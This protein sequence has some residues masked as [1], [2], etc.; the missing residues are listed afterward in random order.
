MKNRML[1]LVIGIPLSSVLLGMV[2]IFLAVNSPDQRLDS[3][4]ALSKTS[5]R[6]SVEEDQRGHDG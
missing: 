2:M 6:Q 1:M 4:H 3:D 5:W